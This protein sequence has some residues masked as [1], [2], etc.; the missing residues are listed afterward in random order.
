M[1]VFVPMF[2]DSG[3]KQK[4]QSSGGG[5]GWL[6]S[7]CHVILSASALGV[8]DGS[9]IKELFPDANSCAFV[10]ECQNGRGRILG[11]ILEGS[12]DS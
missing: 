8:A 4:G 7:F 3:K 5:I 2:L 10:L 6:N 1:K 9:Y 12:K 11:R